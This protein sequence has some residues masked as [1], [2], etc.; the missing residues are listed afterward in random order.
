MS[1]KSKIGHTYFGTLCVSVTVNRVRRSIEYHQCSA[2]IQLSVDLRLCVRRAACCLLRP[3][4]LP[5][6]AA[7]ARPCSCC[8]VTTSASSTTVTDNSDRTDRTD[9]ADRTDRTSLD[10]DALH[11]GQAVQ[12]G[13]VLPAPTDCSAPSSSRTCTWPRGHTPPRTTARR[14]GDQQVPHTA[15]LTA[16]QTARASRFTYGARS[17][18]RSTQTGALQGGGWQADEPAAT[19]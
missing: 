9:T 2:P 11:V 13:L 1:I 14:H 6:P 16:A 3:T 4:T 12:D 18:A 17:T 15:S 19:A 5:T 10:T 7:A 8:A